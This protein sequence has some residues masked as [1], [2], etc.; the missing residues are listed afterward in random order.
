MALAVVGRHPEFECEW[1]G[2]G[3]PALSCVTV[4][5]GPCALLR[6]EGKCPRAPMPPCGFRLHFPPHPQ[7]SPSAC[8]PSGPLCHLEHHHGLRGAF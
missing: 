8:F 4:L 3:R 2:V 1:A 7:W 6:L 5:H